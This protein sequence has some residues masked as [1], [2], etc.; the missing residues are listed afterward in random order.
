M[1]SGPSK[2]DQPRLM[3]LF[4]CWDILCLLGWLY[5]LYMYIVNC[6]KPIRFYIFTLHSSK[7]ILHKSQHICPVY[8]FVVFFLHFWHLLAVCCVVKNFKKISVLCVVRVVKFQPF[9][10]RGRW[11]TRFVWGDLFSFWHLETCKSGEANVQ[12]NIEH[13]RVKDRMA[14]GP[15]RDQN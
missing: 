4:N 13:H 2:V 6:C 5:N 9:N 8:P 1:D 14:N 11:K 7:F 15:M 12:S 3:W 10:Q